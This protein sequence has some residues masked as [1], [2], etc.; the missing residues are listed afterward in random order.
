VLDIHVGRFSLD[1]ATT[2]YER[3]ER[4]CIAVIDGPKL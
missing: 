3:V 4:G 1:D 2:A